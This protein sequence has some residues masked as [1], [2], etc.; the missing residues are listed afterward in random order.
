M[1]IL[2]CS[3]QCYFLLMNFTAERGYCHRPLSPDDTAFLMKE[4]YDFSVENNRL[5]L[6]R[7]EWM[8]AATCLHSYI[9]PLYYSTV[10]V[11]SLLDGWHIPVLQFVMMIFV[12]AKIYAIGFYHYME[13]T[14][15]VPPENL[16]PYFATEGPYL[17]GIALVLT[18]IWNA[19]NAGGASKT[20][21]N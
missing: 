6:E 5:F 15:H 2:L 10:F 20:K 4:T 18:H 9:F 3:L 7:P 21:K 13:F 14:S 12:G 16:V 17:L 8:R 11:T 19:Q 1:K